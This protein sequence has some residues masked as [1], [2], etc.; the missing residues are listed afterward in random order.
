MNELPGILAQAPEQATLVVF[1]SAV[2]PYVS[3]DRR[4]AF[5]D[6]LTQFSRTR[7]IVWLSN[8]GRGALPRIDALAPE[9]DA[10]HFLMARTTLQLKKTKAEFLGI[11][12]AH[13]AELQWFADAT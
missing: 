4:N 6:V 3:P 11:A 7:S 2:L 9:T 8:E 5:A 12:H 1:H 10:L 13:G